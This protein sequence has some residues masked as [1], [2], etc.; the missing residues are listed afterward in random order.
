MSGPIQDYMGVPLNFQHNTVLSKFG[1]VLSLSV[2]MLAKF[3]PLGLR[4]ADS[5]LSISIKD[6]F[7]MIFVRADN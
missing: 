4:L 7:A 1:I 3:M 6:H 2:I 5:I